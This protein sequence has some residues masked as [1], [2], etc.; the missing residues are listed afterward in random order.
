MSN[1]KLVIC[2]KRYS[3][4]SLRP[5]FLLKQAGIP[6]QEV[7][8]YLYKDDSDRKIRQY[9]AAGKVPILIDG[10][11]TVW[12]SLAICEYIAEKFPKKKL[13]PDNLKARAVA[14]SIS[15]E[16]HA[17]F[18][19]LRQ[20][21]PHNCAIKNPFKNIPPLVQKDISRI[22]ELWID[23]RS[24]NGK[25]GDFLFGEFSIADCMYAPV[26]N[27]F[28]TYDVQLGSV[29]EKYK[30]AVLSLPVL[31]EWIKEGQ[32]ETERIEAYEKK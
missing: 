13:W 15:H 16:M 21:M 7:K 5:W 22:E 19:N 27:R 2:N 32:R 3:S 6:F 8:I 17:G 1:L 12:E 25:G 30:E 29:G 24:K 14:R 20:H 10:E 4:W 26:V 23:C 18:M 31:K 9:S 11:L 28:V